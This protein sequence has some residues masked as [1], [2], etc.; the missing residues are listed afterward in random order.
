MEQTKSRAVPLLPLQDAAWINGALEA[1]M[2]FILNSTETQHNH[3]LFLNSLKRYQ[4]FQEELE[5]KSGRGVQLLMSGSVAENLFAIHWVYKDG[6]REANNDIDVMLVDRS[7]AVLERSQLERLDI[8]AGKELETNL[9][10]KEHTAMRSQ[11]SKIKT[12]CSLRKGC[13]STESE[14][15]G[16][17][18]PAAEQK[19]EEAEEM[20]LKDK[21]K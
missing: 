20:A 5:S 14:S 21:C 3:R 6:R 16:D 10:M 15:F 13:Q 17:L 12:D 8:S 1:V 9:D 18:L 19:G 4:T 7:I 2:K 11:P